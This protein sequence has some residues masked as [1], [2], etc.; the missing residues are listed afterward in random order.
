MIKAI[1]LDMDNTLLNNAKKISFKNQMILKK[2]HQRGLKIILCSGRPIDGIYPYLE[3]LGLLKP[4]DACICFNGGLVALTASKQKIATTTLLPNDFRPIFDLT[5]KEHFIFY[6]VSEH[7]VYAMLQ[8]SNVS[9][10]E[11]QMG[12][13][14]SFINTKFN[15]IPPRTP[16]YKAVIIDT[17][18]K[19]AELGKQIKKTHCFHVTRSRSTFLEVLP[20][21]VNKANG[22]KA[23]LNY[24][25]IKNSELIAFGDEA[26]DQEMIQYAGIGVA[27]ANAIP[28]LKKIADQITSTNEEDGVANFLKK[29]FKI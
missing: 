23:F 21:Q 29:Y 9:P 28:E 13:Y 3:E 22:L 12:K 18:V 20:L 7:K 15:Q 27:M 2:L 26:N 1:A 14:L 6:L 10:Y 25:K 24:F 19:I 16:I 4:H 11:E 8:N 5:K 17:P